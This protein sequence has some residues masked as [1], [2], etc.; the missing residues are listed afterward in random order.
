MWKKASPTYKGKEEAY[1]GAI[2]VE[3]WFLS[4]STVTEV[5]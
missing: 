4:H 5:W 3:S 1:I 2:V